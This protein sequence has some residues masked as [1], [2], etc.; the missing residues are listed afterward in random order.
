ML[1]A[2][3]IEAYYR[4]VGTRMAGLPVC[5]PALAVELLGWRAV[6]GVGAL[7]V[8]ITPWCMNLFWRPP[9]GA[10]LPAKGERVVLALPSGDY[11][12]TLHEDETLGRYAS[13]SLCS[14]MQDF[15]GQAEA[16]AMA[17]EVLRLIFAEPE[18]E[19]ESPQPAQL[20][21]R[22]LF[23]RALGGTP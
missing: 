21:R 19:P 1:A 4:A 11:E 6:E 10:E 14:P 22:A 23:R 7:G 9:A 18:S 15:P 5:N 2:A 13:A 17:E 16:R 8:L 12:C 3:D 20:T